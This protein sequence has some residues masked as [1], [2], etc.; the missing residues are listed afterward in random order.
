MHTRGFKRLA[1]MMFCLAVC[2]AFSGGCVAIVHAHARDTNLALSAPCNCWI[3]PAHRYN[4][5][6]MH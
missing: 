5:S 3:L 2:V 4:W 1:L 6:S